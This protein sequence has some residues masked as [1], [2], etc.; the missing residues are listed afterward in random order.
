[1]T[2][3]SYQITVNVAGDLVERGAH[4][5]VFQH[6]LQ[7]AYP[8]AKVTVGVSLYRDRTIVEIGGHPY[9][10]PQ[11]RTVLE[12]AERLMRNMSPKGMRVSARLLP[13]FN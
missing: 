2:Q 3:K 9:P 10:G 1:M 8:E 7:S 6:R 12:G 11:E 5:D 13:G 4:L